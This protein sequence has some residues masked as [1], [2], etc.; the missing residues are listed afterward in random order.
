LTLP[1]G[2][3]GTPAAGMFLALCGKVDFFAHSSQY[4]IAH[5]KGRHT[6]KYG[7]QPT[8]KHYAK[9]ST[10]WNKME[11]QGISADKGGVQA[12][13]KSE[14]VAESTRRRRRRNRTNHHWRGY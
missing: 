14:A 9:K 13:M 3:A 2:G 4:K 11:K 7:V 12:A 5:K 1:V 6:T 10:F 8:K